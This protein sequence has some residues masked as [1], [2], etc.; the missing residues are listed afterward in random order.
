MGVDYGEFW[1]LSPKTLTPFVKA[2]SLKEQREDELLWRQ[3][4]YIA[5]AIGSSFSKEAKY[6]ER[7]FM[8]DKPL[9]E[10]EKRKQLQDK[11]LQHIKKVN[12]QFR[13][14]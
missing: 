13:G 14:D 5:K 11:I 12:T 6:P 2:F 10:E 3:G 7:P 8:A 1:E 9:S 4:L